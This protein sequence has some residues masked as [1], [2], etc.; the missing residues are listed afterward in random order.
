MAELAA[1]DLR[2]ILDLLG[3]AHQ[4][5]GAAEFSEVLMLGL[6]TLIG[7]DLVSYN[8]IDLTGGATR[9]YFEPHLAPHPEIEKAFAQLIAQHPLVRDYAATGDPRPRLMSDYLS[10]SQLHRLDLYEH[11]FKPL[12]TNHQLAFSLAVDSDQVIGIG[13]NRW[14]GDFDAREVS[15]LTVL[16][17]HL[18]AAYE[19]ALLRGKQAADRA[20]PTSGADRLAALTGR[21]REVAALVADGLSNRRIARLLFISERTAEVHVAR[22]LAKL[23]VASRVGAA[24]VY[25]SE[26]GSG[27]W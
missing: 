19:H 13:L 10:L 15:V 21:E 16:Q 3:D 24:K 8:E 22:I 25:L 9:T 12:E 17:P 1:E 18:S 14:R 26:Q 5:I 2:R 23:G 6:V 4:A 27:R 11:V 7:C 20:A